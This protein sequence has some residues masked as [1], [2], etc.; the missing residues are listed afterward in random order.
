MGLHHIERGPK[1]I[2]VS[3]VLLDF[4]GDFHVQVKW[5]SV[6]QFLSTAKQGD[7]AL[8]SMSPP[9]ICLSICLCVLSRLNHL[10]S[11][12]LQYIL[13]GQFFSFKQSIHIPR[14]LLSTYFLW[15]T[16]WWE[17][18]TRWY[19]L[20]QRFLLVT[21]CPEIT[22]Y[23]ATLKSTDVPPFYWKNLYVWGNSNLYE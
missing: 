8:G 17:L 22:V 6:C 15:V 19:S 14:M 12:K 21:E 1:L 11:P 20:P 13:R 4:N 5:S 10:T 23:H 9:F 18:K 16:V 7:N 2:G 3:L